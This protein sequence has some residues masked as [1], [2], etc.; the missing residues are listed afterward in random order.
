MLSREDGEALAGTGTCRMVAMDVR[1]LVVGN[2][3]T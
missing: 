3:T 2:N 1:S